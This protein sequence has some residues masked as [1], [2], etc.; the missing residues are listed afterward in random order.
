MG[1]VPGRQFLCLW[2]RD[3]DTPMDYWALQAFTRPGAVFKDFT[4]LL[5]Y[6]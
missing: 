2:V 1:L 5:C 4:T 3:M 6:T